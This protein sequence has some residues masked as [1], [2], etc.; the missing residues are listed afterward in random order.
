MLESIAQ[1]KQR[2]LTILLIEHKL[3]LVM[4]LSDRVM[5]MDNGQKIAEGAPEVVRNAPASSRPISAT[6]NMAEMPPSQRVTWVLNCRRSARSWIRA[7]LRHD[8]GDVGS[9]AAIAGC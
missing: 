3:T 2:Q 1:L 5:V 6:S 7:R 9:A 4:Q 8:H